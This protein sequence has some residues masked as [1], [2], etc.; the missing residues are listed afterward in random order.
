MSGRNVVVLPHIPKVLGGNL[1]H[2][3]GGSIFVGCATVILE[4]VGVT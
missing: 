4:L 2:I 1:K 3:F